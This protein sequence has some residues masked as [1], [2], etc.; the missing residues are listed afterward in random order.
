[1]I[2]MGVARIF[3]DRHNFSSHR[4]GVPPVYR[5]GGLVIMTFPLGYFISLVAFA[6][7][8]LALTRV[9]FVWYEIAP[10]DGRYFL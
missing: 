4:I 6:H 2:F 3:S 5:G 8:S 7:I 9:S 10:K 1:M